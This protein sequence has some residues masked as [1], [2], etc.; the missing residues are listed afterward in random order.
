M[1]Q[2]YANNPNKNF[3]FTNMNL[4][5]KIRHSVY[6]EY[7]YKCKDLQKDIEEK[8]ITFLVIGA[9]QKNLQLALF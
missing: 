5:K 3:R 7:Y 1:V 8:K 2:G 6:N 9:N 4:S